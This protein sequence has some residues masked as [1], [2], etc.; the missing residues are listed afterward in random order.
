MRT[1]IPRLL[2]GCV[3]AIVAAAGCGDPTAPAQASG[4][5]VSAPRVE[6]KMMLAE[7]EAGPARLGVEAGEVELRDVTFYDTADLQLERAGTILRT[8]RV[9]GGGDDDDSTV[10]L[11]PMTAASVAPAFLEE[12]GFKCELDKNVG[13]PAVSSCS[14]TEER[15]AG[16]IASVARGAEPITTLFTSDQESYLEMHQERFPAIWPRLR[17]LG[18]IAAEVW[19]A[20]P[21]EF[22]GAKVTVERW[23]VPG[24]ARSL[25]VSVKVSQADAAAFEQKLVAW[26]AGR[27]LHAATVQESKTRAALEALAAQLAS[28]D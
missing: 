19:K 14:L 10:K 2:G 17:P 22:D 27:G 15:E 28:P 26:V 25:E 16:V 8:R 12:K 4:E 21:S 9:K 23:D 6:V 5:V 20:A 11:R 3:V 18:P 24:G 1:A 13:A 7:V